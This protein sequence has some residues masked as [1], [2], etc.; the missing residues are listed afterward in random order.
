VQV[1]GRPI[2][3]V[4]T[5]ELNGDCMITV[6]RFG[7]SIVKSTQQQALQAVIAALRPFIQAD[8]T[9]I[10]GMISFSECDYEGRK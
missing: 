2:R 5:K 1:A 10:R 8:D 3:A 6:P 7:I 4:I 9:A